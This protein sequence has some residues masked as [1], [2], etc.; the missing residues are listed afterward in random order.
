MRLSSPTDAVMGVLLS[1]I[2]G[3][4]VW[5]CSKLP[6][7]SAVRMGPGYFPTLV[8]WILVG[9]GVILLARSMIISGPAIEGGKLRPFV[10]VLAAVLVFALGIQ[11][12]GLLATILLMVPISALGSRD[13]RPLEVIAAALVLGLF[14]SALFVGL[15]GLPMS[16][17]PPG[18]EWTAPAQAPTASGLPAPAQAPTRGAP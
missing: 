2:G 9:F 7:G 6:M 17:L 15:L 3:G 13:L 1:I 5:L 11:H 12:L 10:F 18:L 16:W 14:S 4:G 8:S